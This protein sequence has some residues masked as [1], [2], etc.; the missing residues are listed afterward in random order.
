MGAQPDVW[1][2]IWTAM[3]SLLRGL[4]V[5]IEISAIAI[6]VGCAW[7]LAPEDYVLPMHR[8]LGVWTTRGVP[9]APLFCQLM[10]R[11]GGYTFDLTR[12]ILQGL[13]LAPGTVRK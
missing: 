10:G 6:A 7:A 3:P 13:F 1:T 12:L 8:N 11:E 4:L 2:A 9:L 5:T